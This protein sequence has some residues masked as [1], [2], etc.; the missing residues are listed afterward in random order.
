MNKKRACLYLLTAWMLCFSMDVTRVRSFMLPF[1]ARPINADDNGSGKYIGIGWS[2]DITTG[3]SRES[4]TKAF[5][6]KLF[7]ITLARS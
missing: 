2:F 6:V 3:A 7:G 5:A 4:K 1:F